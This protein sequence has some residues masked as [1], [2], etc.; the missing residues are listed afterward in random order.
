MAR[1]GTLL[2]VALILGACG[3]PA[4][5]RVWLQ[6]AREI[7]PP[8]QLLKNPGLEQVEGGRFADWQPWQAGYQV[9]T[10]VRHGGRYSA[11][12]V[13]D[14]EGRQHGL[15]QT[16]VLNQKRPVPILARAWSRAQN[17]SGAPD[18]NYSLYLDL[19]YTDGTPLWGQKTP[20][21][22][23]THDWEQAVV[24]VAPEKP[25]RSVN[26]YGIFRG[27]KG[28]AWFD[29]FE[30][31]ELSSAGLFDFQPGIGEPPKAGR[32]EKLTAGG[33]VLYID[34]ATGAMSLDGQRLGGIVVRDFAA[35]SAYVLPELSVKRQGNKIVLSGDIRELNLRIDAML[36]LEDDVAYLDG[37]V[38]DTSGKDR[39][40][41]VYWA[42]PVPRERWVF[43][44]D[45][46]RVE[47]CDDQ[48]VHGNLMRV[49]AGANGLASHYPFAPIAAGRTG[50]A[51]GAPIRQ[52]RL[53]RFAFDAGRAVLYAAF[54]L[55]LSPATERFPSAATFHAVLFSFDPT[56][57]FRSALKRYYELNGD[58]FACRVPKQ[59]IWMPFTDIARVQGWEDFGF[60]FQEGAPNPAF[61][62]QHGIY[63]FPYIEPM[64]YWMAMP[65]DMPRT[66]EAALKLLREQAL[67]GKR[68]AVAT[69]SSGLYGP[70]GRLYMSFHDVP[71][72]NGALI[73][74]NPDPS[75]VPPKD[76]PVTKWMLIEQVVNRVVND[77]GRGSQTAYWSAY[78]EGYEVVEGEGRGGSRCAKVVRKRGDDAMGLDQYVAIN[79]TKP[80]PLIA[81][82]WSK[83]QGVTGQKDSD[84]SLYIDVT[85]TD[86]TH[87]WGQVAA[88][89]TGTHDWQQATV[90]IVPDKPVASVNVHLL[91]RGNHY[92][93]VWFDDVSLREE[94]STRELIRGGDFERRKSDVKVRID[95]QYIDSLEMACTTLNYR[96]E[97]FAAADLPLVF[98]RAG[99]VAQ[100][101]HFMVMEMIQRME[102]MLRP[103]GKWLFANAVLHR[104]PWPAGWLDIFGTETNWNRGGTYN[105]PSDSTMLYWRAM[106]YKRPYLTLQNTDFDKFPPKLVEKYFQRCCYYGVLPSMFSPVASGSSSYWIRPDL[107]NRD[108]HLFKKYIPVIR[109]IAEAGWEP[110]PYARTD[111]DDVWV[112]RFG[113]GHEVFFTIFNDNRKQP[114]TATVTIELKQ[115]LASA[116][117]TA[118]LLLPE[119]KPVALE[120]GRLRVT[121][122]P[123]QVAVLRLSVE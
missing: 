109:R 49:G 61:D 85:Y 94:G 64:S 46:R 21:Q 106:C 2:V 87:K 122:Q 4:S 41:I 121:L 113:G 86:G 115:V 119:R 37:T 34:P 3:R 23:G 29:D 8:G 14:P 25:I 101:G 35:D 90:R 1:I 91:V 62:E 10:Q 95:G 111:R 65:K 17:V 59:G 31:Y 55:G 51:V 96:R 36:R 112:E 56:W 67:Q 16:V 28:T 22:T 38:R 105:P 72:C 39:A 93:T 88:F 78:G 74:L 57:R 13:M 30:L 110:I 54:D 11:R 12:C 44:R 69:L 42:L 97:H 114:R 53:C 100:L 102:E 9:D 83:A 70:D 68:L 82:A 118:E 77:E 80:T 15:G 108:R 75:I 58:A 66:E 33:L 76:A 123:E 26:V 99:R 27:H 48:I 116:V 52:P 107:Y 81:T 60:Q 40:V 120:G 98:D 18:G 19:E 43:L 45:P 7:K 71:W 92:G 117:K 5:A 6:S 104:F 89:D 50:L 84:Y 63:S 73:L 24:V 47:S 32:M 103:R 20:F 79:Q